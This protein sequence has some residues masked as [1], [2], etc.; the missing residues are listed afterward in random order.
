MKTEEQTKEHLE[1]TITKFANE[2]YEIGYKDGLNVK[3]IIE[4]D[5]KQCPRYIL[6]DYNKNRSKN[7]NH[8]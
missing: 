7:E 1:K 4:K 6:N 5:Y 8:L 2:I 3:K